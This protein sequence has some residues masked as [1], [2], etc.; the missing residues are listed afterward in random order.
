MSLNY[1]TFNQNYS[2]LAVGGLF[3]LLRSVQSTH[4]D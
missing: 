3:L 2:H 4:A 1:V